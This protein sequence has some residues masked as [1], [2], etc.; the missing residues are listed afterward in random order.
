MGQP[1]YETSDNP[2]S[3]NRT[4]CR[5][6]TASTATMANECLSVEN[7]TRAAARGTLFTLVLRLISFVCTQLTIRALD[8]STLGTSIQLELILTTILFISREGFRLALTQNVVPENQ[9]VAWLTIPVVTFISGTTMIWHL[10]FATSSDEVATDYRIA[11]VLYCIASWVEGSG[12]PA[13][14]F[15]LRKLEVPPRVEAEG[16][17]TVAKTVAT[18]V[19]IQF[20]PSS[21]TITAFGLAQLVYATIYTFYL[22]GRALSTPDWNEAGSP[23]SSLSV[24]LSGLD[25]NTCYTTFVYTIQGFFKHMLTE[26]D[27]I[28][29]TAMSDSYNQGVYAMGA[30]YGGMAARILL[31][32]LEENARLL[33]SRLASESDK[34]NT[35]HQNDLFRSYTTL[36]K[37][38]LYVGLVFGCFAVHYTGLLLNILAGRTWG[39]NIEASNILAG[40]CVYTSFLAL[41]GMTEAFVY[42]VGGGDTAA[43][44]M[45]KLGLVHTAT[46]VAFASTAY[47]FVGR[48]GTLGIVIA[49]CV[50]M[51]IRS[52]YSLHFAV[53]YFSKSQTGERSPLLLDL[54]PHPVVLAAFALAWLATR[55]SLENLAAN[56]FH[57][58]LEI[59]N[60]DWL[61][62]T[63]WH[64]VTGIVFLAGIV[65][66]VGTFERRF[67]K[68]LKNMVQNRKSNSKDQKA[69]RQKQD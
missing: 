23:P 4:S 55:L 12:E 49:N 34:H 33:W 27:K 63:G 42:A 65:L 54:C 9:T 3:E 14:L 51:F 17:A 22:Y 57:L 13:V 50:A 47:L 66:L 19:G 32:P 11:G 48:Y 56:G 26:A 18:A 59:R 53:A 6:R 45:T 38:V 36:V 64:V 2:T 60:S 52:L 44:E 58:R 43:T 31:Q 5:D 62:Q 15:F 35:V 16:I 28:V 61:V 10:L 1:P 21:W 25:G 41:N 30:S 29:L 24:F 37:L 8:P 20:L 69:T 7:V 46:G 68:S 39:S 40:F 67:I